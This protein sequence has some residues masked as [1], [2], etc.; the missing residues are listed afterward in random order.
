MVALASLLAGV[1]VLLWL[2]PGGLGDDEPVL[3][4]GGTSVDVYRSITE[5]VADTPSWWGHLL[6]LATEGTLVVLGLVLLWVWFAALRAGN[7]A[8][9]AG[10][11]VVGVGMVA[12][13]GISEALKLVVDEERPCRAVS[14]ADALAECPPVGDWSF[15]SNHSTLAAALGVGLAILLPRLAAVTLPLA[16]LGALLRVAVGVH[17][18]HDV[19]AGAT[20]GATVTAAV[21]LALGPAAVRPTSAVFRGWLGRQPGP[22][23]QHRRSRAVAHAQP[24]EDRADMGLDGALDHVQPPGDLPVGQ[25]VPEAGQHLT[26]P[27]GQG[28]HPAPGGAPV[29]GRA[30]SL[31]GQMGDHPDRDPR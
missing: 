6:E 13:Y 4:T 16:A 29:G 14:G 21:L 9:V 19:L 17:Y 23:G 11:V 24:R 3:V 25:P 2:S 10:A 15:P 1:G 30:R 31:G 8:R 22:V 27:N 5:W 28:G 12:A 18:P 7:A 20:L 26:L